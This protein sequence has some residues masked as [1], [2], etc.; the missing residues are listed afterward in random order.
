MKSLATMIPLLAFIQGWELQTQK[1]PCTPTACF[2]VMGAEE[3]ACG[4]NRQ[5]AECIIDNNWVK[6]NSTLQL[7]CD[8]KDGSSHEMKGT[9]A[10]NQA[11]LPPRD[12]TSAPAHKRSSNVA[13]GRPGLWTSLG[14]F[15]LLLI[16]ILVLVK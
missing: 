3:P 6:W 11:T 14:I 1:L 5:T 8:C 10:K 9:V 4:V 12:A 2:L 16:C 15:V 7:T 13:L